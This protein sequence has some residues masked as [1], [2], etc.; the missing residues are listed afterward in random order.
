MLRKEITKSIRECFKGEGGGRIQTNRLIEGITLDWGFVLIRKDL[1]KMLMMSFFL[2]LQGQFP[3]F[4]STLHLAIFT[5]AQYQGL[6]VNSYLFP[7]GNENLRG[8][9]ILHAAHQDTSEPYVKTIPRR[10]L[11]SH[12][13]RRTLQIQLY[14][15]SSNSCLPLFIHVFL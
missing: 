12:S 11:I 6:G 15:N 13:S 2:L 3:A 5:H 4:W 14:Q 1:P 9:K 8:C 7:F 10:L